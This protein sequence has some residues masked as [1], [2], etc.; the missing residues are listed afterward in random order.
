MEKN[1]KSAFTDLRLRLFILFF[2]D[3]EDHPQHTG[4]QLGAFD[5]NDFHK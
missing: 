1:R 3:A 4:K 5:H 2:F